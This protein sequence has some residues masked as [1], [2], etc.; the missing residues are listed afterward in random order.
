MKDRENK[1]LFFLC[2]GLFP[3]FLLGRLFIVWLKNKV[4]P[5]NCTT[6]SKM[7]NKIKQKNKADHQA[8]IWRFCT[9]AMLHGGKNRFFFLWEKIFLMQNIFIVPAM[10]HGCHAKPLNE[11]KTGFILITDVGI[12]GVLHV[13]QC[14]IV[15]FYKKLSQKN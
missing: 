5:L 15:S 12:L 8:T 10:Q 4:N 6:T 3:K 7:G 2:H 13:Y 1:I 9:A 14:K 11:Y